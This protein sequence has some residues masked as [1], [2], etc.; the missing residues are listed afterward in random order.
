MSVRLTQT[1]PCVFADFRDQRIQDGVERV[2]MTLSCC[3]MLGT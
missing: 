1:K 3:A 2:S